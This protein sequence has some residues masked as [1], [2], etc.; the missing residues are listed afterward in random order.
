MASKSGVGD[1]IRTA[2]DVALAGLEWGTTGTTS[3]AIRATRTILPSAL[4][5]GARV[6]AIAKGDADKAAR[7]LGA[8]ETMDIA[9]AVLRATRDRRLA[10]RAP[11]PPLVRY[12]SRSG[13]STRGR[14]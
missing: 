14:P 12:P 9:Q 5:L 13:A 1:A 8:L 11:T 4:S 6:I 10:K 3:D 2:L 7:M